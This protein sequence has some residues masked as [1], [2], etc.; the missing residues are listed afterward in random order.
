MN[1]NNVR[2]VEFRRQVE[3]NN[4]QYMEK[5]KAQVSAI[6]AFNKT[7]LEE[8]GLQYGEIS[9]R[10]SEGISRMKNSRVFSTDEIKEVNDYSKSL[11]DT[12]YQEAKRDITATLRENFE[13]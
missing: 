9:D 5:I 6:V 7:T 3:T 1:R 12:R 10:L 13:F 11:L 2:K 8:L 4:Q